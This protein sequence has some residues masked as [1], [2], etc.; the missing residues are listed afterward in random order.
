MR[1]EKTQLQ[2]ALLIEPTV[3]GD[4]R[5]WFMEVYSRARFDG[6]GIAFEA[7]QSN[8]SFSAK[9]HTLRGLHCQKTPM[10]QAKLISCLRGVILDVAV[11]IREGSPTYLQHITV[12]LSAENKKMLLVP[13]GFLHGFLTLTD[14]AEVEYKLDNPFS[15]EHDRS[16]SYSDPIFGI[17]WGTDAPVLSAKDAAAPFLKDSDVRF[18]YQG[19]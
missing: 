6:L 8:R 12:E 19:V 3:H 17:C 9:K 14:D 16:V 10:E 4:T 1:A 15:S 18:V 7:V 5:G 13:R 11:D 2:D